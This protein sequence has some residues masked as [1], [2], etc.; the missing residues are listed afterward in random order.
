MNV[1][2]VVQRGLLISSMCSPFS[3]MAFIAN[4]LRKLSAFTHSAGDIDPQGVQFWRER[5]YNYTISA[6]VILGLVVVIPS[7]W[8]SF[9]VGYVGLGIFDIC[10]YLF[11]LVLYFVRGLSYR[12]RAS[13]LMILA[14]AVGI[15]VFLLTGDEGA[16]FFWIFAVP[17]LAS[18]LLGLRAG[19]AFLLL[20]AAIVTAIGVLIGFGIPL[21][22][23]VMEFS[24]ASWVVYSLNFLITDAIVTV[25]FG[26]LLN[27]LRKSTSEATLTRQSM[28]ARLAELEAIRDISIALRSAL[29][30]KEMLPAFL[31]SALKIMNADLG[32]IW[33]YDKARDQVE[34]AF[35]RGYVDP[36]GNAIQI[37]PEKPGSGLAGVVFGTGITHVSHD[38]KTDPAVPEEVRKH[39]IPNVGGVTIPI[40]SELDVI[41]VL[42]VNT[43]FPRQVEDIEVNLLTTLAEIAGS[44]IQ[45]SL[46][47]QKT[48][49]QLEHLKALSEIDRTILTS[50]DKKLN[51]ATVVKIAVDQLGADAVN[52][53]LFDPVFRS[54]KSAVGHG[55]RTQSFEGREVRLGEGNA[56]KAALERRTITIDNLN[57]Q[58]DNPRLARALEGEGFVAYIGVPLIANGQMQGVMEVFER[59]QVKPD[60]ER[61]D[62][63]N[64]LA[65]QAAIA[66][67]NA[68]LFEELQRAND[69]LTMAYDAA[70]EG[71]SRALD[72]RDEE[73]EGHTLRVTDLTLKLARHIGV[74]DEEYVHMR[75][76]ALLHDIGKMGIPDSILLKP[77]P[78]TDEE[79]VV[80]KQH[81]AHAR[82]MLEPI[83][84][85]QKALEIPY[86]HHEKWDGSGYPR[87]LKGEE[88]PKAAR[89]FA[90]ADVY[91]ALT[92]DRPYR[93]AWTKE[94][95]VAYIREQSG[96]HFDPAVV[97]AFLNLGSF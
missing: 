72:M 42:S 39:A 20:N 77:G 81:P 6:M 54:L 87:G 70:I 55:F 11:I 95:T 34:V 10:A 89:I 63:L 28:E 58:S 9:S 57:E 14:L 47:H 43:I 97:D 92:S 52:I 4:S 41:G 32:A 19:T 60:R 96:T 62:L 84:F 35:S 25:P 46:L 91:D 48:E 23:R 56:G 2:L 79:W 69:G 29:T 82:T 61:L 94:R 49:R 3:T 64:T 59:E 5:I 13:A 22:P 15:V 27:G 71:W 83:V 74:S 53:M 24:L 88:I 1:Q 40:R 38:Y 36:E 31:D 33:L 90:V 7:A 86:M 76:G 93:K 85:L 51:L 37:P 8:L 45:R 75:R 30:L 21:L 66:I 80:M 73:T 78:L 50:L 12:V 18:L 67:N 44:S 26:A 68:S 65:G 17:P 16:G